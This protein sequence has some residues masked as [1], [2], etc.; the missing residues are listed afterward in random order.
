MISLGADG[1]L[2]GSC[3]ELEEEKKEQ[4]AHECM[5]VLFQ[6]WQLRTGKTLQG[7]GAP[8]ALQEMY[9]SFQQ[10]RSRYE[11]TREILN[12]DESRLTELTADK[13]C[14]E[15]GQ[16]FP[17]RSETDAARFNRHRKE[18]FYSSFECGCEVTWDSETG[19]KRH[20]LLRHEGK[21]ECGLCSYIGG[22]AGLEV[23]YEKRRVSLHLFVIIGS[24]FP[25]YLHS[26]GH[27]ENVHRE[28][29]CE[30][31]ATKLKVGD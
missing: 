8:K 29:T 12:S 3:V 20:I 7:A 26:K 6:V 13:Q 9:K 24:F 22:K 14:A 2:L 17:N 16:L 1:R 10:L 30:F 28:M 11:V 27:M 19:K 18:H 15:C 5:D 21:V 25:L 31:C 23:V 4:S